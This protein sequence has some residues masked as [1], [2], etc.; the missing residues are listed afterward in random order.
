MKISELKE[1]DFTKFGEEISDVTAFHVKKLLKI[2][3][4][5]DVSKDDVI[6]FS[7]FLFKMLSSECTFE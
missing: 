7:S 3:D 4:T 1:K 6:E 2:A 5:Y